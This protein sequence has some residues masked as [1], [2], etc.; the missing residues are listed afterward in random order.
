MTAKLSNIRF[1]AYTILVLEVIFVIVYIREAKFTIRANQELHIWISTLTGNWSSENWYTINSYTGS[2]RYNK[3]PLRYSLA[4]IA[5]ITVNIAPYLILFRFI[6]TF[7]VTEV[8][9]MGVI[10]AIK[11]RDRA[12]K[13]TFLAKIPNSREGSILISR[14][15]ATDMLN[16]AFEEANL[17]F[18]KQID[19]LE[20][21]RE[22]AENIKRKISTGNL[23]NG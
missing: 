15:E 5:A 17:L 13:N 4:A 2:I 1:L 7:F 23:E 19:D 20:P 21:N 22:K 12:I 8:K 3:N 9:V 6:K 11:L 18:N 10:N 14:A 16:A